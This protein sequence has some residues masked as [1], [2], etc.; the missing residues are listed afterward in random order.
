MVMVMVVVVMVPQQEMGVRRA[1]EANRCDSSAD[2]LGGKEGGSDYTGEDSERFKRAGS[3]LQ[4]NNEWGK[5][6]RECG[7]LGYRRAGGGAC[8][9]CTTPPHGGARNSAGAGQEQRRPVAC[10]SARD[11]R[12]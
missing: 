12:R 11:S 6:E 7:C 8:E 1:R 10:S 3:R 5:R 2:P 4:A 9:T